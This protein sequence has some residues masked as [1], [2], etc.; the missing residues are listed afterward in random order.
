MAGTSIRLDG[1]VSALLRQMRRYSEIDRKNLNAALAESARASTLERFRQSRSPEGRRWTTSVRAATTGG[2]TLVD[3]AQL[4]NSIKSYSDEKGFAVGT[5]AKHGS[6][7]QFGDKG[8]TIR[9][10]TSKGLR[11]VGK[12]GK[13]VT[14]RQ[15]TVKIPARPFLGLSSEDMDEIKA[16]VEE[17]IGGEG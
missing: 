2:K 14:K 17:F 6:T 5:N 8:R 10:K 4:R 15:V 12:N 7:H 16:T 11:F 3:S 9:A 1:D 13:W